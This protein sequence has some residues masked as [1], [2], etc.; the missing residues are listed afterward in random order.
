[1]QAP[2]MQGGRQI[3]AVYNAR[4]MERHMSIYFPQEYNHSLLHLGYR[5]HYET[6]LIRQ[7]QPDSWL[8]S[9]KLGM[10]VYTI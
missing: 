10:S 7:V 5:H 6:S 4:Q 1:M 8:R 2:L 3:T 9:G